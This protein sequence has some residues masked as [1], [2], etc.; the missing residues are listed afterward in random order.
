VEYYNRWRLE[1]VLKDGGVLGDGEHDAP[2]AGRK[3]EDTLNILAELE[4]VG[5]G[6][7][8]FPF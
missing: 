5:D 3:S 4:P 2:H 1:A 6:G 8:E 7:G